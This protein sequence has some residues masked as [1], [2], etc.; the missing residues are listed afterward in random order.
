M[1]TVKPHNRRRELCT[2][3]ASRRSTVSYP[4]QWHG[5]DSGSGPVGQT[6]CDCVERLD[7][8]AP[9]Y[10]SYP[11]AD[12]FV[13]AFGPEDHARYLAARALQPAVPL[14][15]YVHI[16][17]CS[18]LCYYCACNKKITQDYAKAE[19]YIEHLISELSMVDSLLSGD[20]RLLQLH[21]GGGTPTYLKS[22]DLQRLMNAITERFSLTSAGE[23]SM[24]IDPRTVDEEKMNVLREAG[25]NRLSLGVQDF[26]VDVQAAIN[27]VQP[28]SL[29]A[30]VLDTG[31]QLGFESTN[32]DL[33]HGLPRQTLAGFARTVEEVIAMRPD[34]IALYN[35]AHLPSR[36]KAQRLINPQDMPSPELKQDIFCLA[37][38]LL[39]SAG[40]DYIGMD[41]FALPE[42]GLA[43]ARRTGRLH[44]NF[45]GYSTQPDC[46]L[47]AI[48]ASSIS[49]IGSCYSQNL[50]GLNEYGDRVSQNIL[51]TQR[52]VEL[53][54]DDILRR[55]VIMAIMC[56]GEI[57]KS[58]FE[59][60]YL[61]DFDQYFEEE[62]QA[63]QP[64]VESG[65]VQLEERC[66][67]VTALGR[68]KALRMVGSQF[69]RYL[70]QHQSRS[71][72][73]TIL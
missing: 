10:T 12:R 4:V 50:K 24:E 9:R 33:I 3:D 60:G 30:S 68:R 66:V 26:D 48:G 45:Q 16:P 73:S 7:M 61:I 39:D 32:F 21:F 64:L 22:V 49:R 37:N 55:A 35:Y 1:K 27:R 6:A 56:Q 44:R 46:D 36:F 2:R 15:L 62:L 17:F 13:E 54:R 19:R 63:L 11:T 5:D 72:F 70:Q 31:R 59:I 28:A 71:R 67:R 47:V 41:H 53:S 40:Y 29:V 42:D 25:F 51:P 8:R 69:D 38:D 65:Y 58:T 20:R 23:Y 52:G 18:A 14:S 34:R 43:N 57:D